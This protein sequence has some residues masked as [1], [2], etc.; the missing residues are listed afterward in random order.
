VSG[1]CA[2]RMEGRGEAYSRVSSIMRCE[3]SIRERSPRSESVAELLAED[4]KALRVRKNAGGS[5]KRAGLYVQG[6]EGRATRLT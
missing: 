2:K 5:V 1:S 6:C 3:L 4:L